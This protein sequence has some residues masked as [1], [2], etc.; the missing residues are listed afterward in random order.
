MLTI[1]QDQK[2]A[3]Y[4]MIAPKGMEENLLI[5]NHSY[6]KVPP[7]A[8]FWGQFWA[9]LWSCFVQVGV[10]SDYHRTCQKTATE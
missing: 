9:S 7:R 2:M 8:I 1:K 6:M 4:V 5:I 3:V 10:V